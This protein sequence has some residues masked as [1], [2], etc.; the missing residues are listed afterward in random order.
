[1]EQKISVVINTYNAELHLREVLETVK[2]FDEI[3]V[4]DMESTDHTV[5]IAKGYGCKIVVFPKKNYKI[6][7]P[8]RMFAIQ[9]ATYPWVL[10][11]DADELVP[12]ELREYLYK[13]IAEP[14]C[15]QGLYIPRLNRFMNKPIKGRI[16]DHQLRFFVRQGTTWPTYIH[17]IPHVEGRVEHIPHLKNVMLVH[18]NESSLHTIIEKD[19]RYSDDEVDKRADKH[20]GLFALFFR[21]AFYFFKNFFIDADYKNGVNG[22]IHASLKAFYQ[23]L[24][25]AKII[26]KR[27]SE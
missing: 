19:N 2:D 20:Y 17:S 4:C 3:V 16:G 15:P 22:F 26:E 11:V 24:L 18:L 10:V 8:A 12:R 5:E 23:F 25:V 27:E 13:R 21:P 1:M 14:D 6:V 7:E 9:S